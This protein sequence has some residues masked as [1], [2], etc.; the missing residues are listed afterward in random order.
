MFDELLWEEAGKGKN[1]V[2]FKRNG[3]SGVHKW[4]VENAGV[5]RVASFEPYTVRYACVVYTDGLE[6]EISQRDYENPD[7]GKLRFSSDD[8]R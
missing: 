6:V 7:C 4:T 1:Y 5:F 3:C 2:D 8:G